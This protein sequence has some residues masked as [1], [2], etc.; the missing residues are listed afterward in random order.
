MKSIRFF[1]GLFSIL[2]SLL[3]LMAC[4]KNKPPAAAEDASPSTA[5]E[6]SLAE[7]EE[8]TEPTSPAETEPD[9]EGEVPETRPETEYEPEA[10]SETQADTAPETEPV[11]ENQ[12]QPAITLSSEE[13][14]ALL[15]AALNKELGDSAVA[16]KSAV[17]GEIYACQTVIRRGEDLQVERTAEGRTEGITVLGDKAYYSLSE[18]DGTQIP[19]SRY[20]MT[21]TEEERAALISRFAENDLATGADGARM[22]EAL[23]KGK[24]S[25]VRHADG[26]VVLTCTEPDKSIV[27]S[28]LGTAA[29]GAT[30][31]F[32]F[33]LDS[34]V[35]LT[36]MACTVTLPAT[37]EGRETV[38]LSEATVC[39][40]PDPLTLPEDVSAYVEITYRELFGVKLPEADPEDAASAGLPL[41]KDHYTFIGENAAHTPEE[42]YLF[43]LIYP[44]SYEGKTF[45]LYGTI[46]ENREGKPVLSL[47]SDMEFVLSFDGA[48]V[49]AVGSYV[50][51]VAVYTKT[52]GVG[53]YADFD[54]YTMAV[55]ACEVLRGATGENGGRLMYV[56][57][58]ALNVRTS[59]DTSS[60]ANII[61]SFAKGEPVEVFEQDEKGWYRVVYNG[62]NA[63][64]NGKYVSE[65]KP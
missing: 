15:S 28:L 59:S 61:G 16:V 49:P 43:M 48:G 34:E 19:P 10:E 41:D 60:A 3:F 4:A 14:K 17:N 30:T 20:G 24:L 31:A 13:L 46:L 1:G 53:D 62:Q 29:E 35:R 32:D 2:L 38:I 47:G 23:M 22:I 56:T 9:T 6:S 26:T 40:R 58:T 18:T 45:T 51:L 36:Y 12:T 63:Y 65:T 57:A 27:E 55:T 8:T 11:T 42:Q 33:V 50:K 44:H 64:I 21:V 5:A 39:Y 25:G 54:C 7:P 52:A 37:A